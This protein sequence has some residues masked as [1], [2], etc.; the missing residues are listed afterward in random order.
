MWEKF[1]KEVVSSGKRLKGVGPSCEK[2]KNVRD[3]IE[4]VL[5]VSAPWGQLCLREV[6]SEGKKEKGRE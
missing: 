4:A 1:D 2:S 3:F 6:S 5:R